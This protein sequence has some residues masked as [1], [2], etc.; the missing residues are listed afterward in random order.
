M[1]R[2]LLSFSAFYVRCV[3]FC[4][5]SL[6]IAL[7]PAFLRFRVLKEKGEPRGENDHGSFP[8]VLSGQMSAAGC[9]H[10]PRFP[11]SFLN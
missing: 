6:R 9:T 8:L 10:D 3:F 5:L 7:R 11:S 4:L 1:R 2:G